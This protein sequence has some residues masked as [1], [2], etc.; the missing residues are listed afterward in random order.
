MITTPIPHTARPAAILCP[1]QRR[2]SHAAEGYRTGS[3]EG[4][5]AGRDRAP[6]GPPPFTRARA[7]TA[8]ATCRRWQAHGDAPVGKVNLKPEVIDDPQVVH[9]RA[10]VEVDHGEAGRVRLARAAA[11]FGGAD[12]PVPKPAAHLGEHGEQV[13]RELGYDDSR[14]A[15][16]VA[17]SAVRLG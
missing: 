17:A 2:S 16:L 11:R 5:R 7:P 4:S 8:P 6:T 10:L 14:I 15:A 12:L 3:H 13:L 9:N 1:L